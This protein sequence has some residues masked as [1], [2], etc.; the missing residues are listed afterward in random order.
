MTFSIPNHCPMPAWADKHPEPF[1][2]DHPKD[3]ET[4]PLHRYMSN[5]AHPFYRNGAGETTLSGA[6]GDVSNTTGDTGNVQTATRT[7]V[8]VTSRIKSEITITTADGDTVTMN[9]ASLFEAGFTAYTQRGEIN[10]SPY[11]IS[12]ASASVNISKEYSL[13]VEGDLDRE[14]MRDIAKAIRQVNK[15]MRRLLSGDMEHALKRASKLYRLDSL[16]AIEAKMETGKSVSV[17]EQVVRSATEFPAPSETM[18]PE[19][20]GEATASAEAA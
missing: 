12:G 6:T 2:K 13:S 1:R 19:I 4:A 14:E 3:P 20:A 11:N 18:S 17:T 9:T 8:T 15:I 5:A 16:A 7:D 10:E